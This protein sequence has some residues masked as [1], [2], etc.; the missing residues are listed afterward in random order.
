MQRVDLSALRL[1][2]MSE[3]LD[4]HSLS[5]DPVH[6]FGLWF[7][8]AENAGID[9]VNAMT[10]ATV[11]GAGRPSARIV[12]LKGFGPSGF[13]F[14]TNYQSRK[15]G[16]LSAQPNVSLLFF[17]QP[18]A[19]QVRIDGIAE[20]LTPKVNDAYFAT[21]PRESQIGAWASAQSTTVPNRAFIEAR[22]AEMTQ[23]FEGQNVP[24]PAYWGGFLVRP[25]AFEFWQG[26]PSRLHDRV[27][28]SPTGQA[29]WLRERLSP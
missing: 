14:F 5:P 19:R 1:E 26:R 27:R 25:L 16:E 11:D 7:K 13:E 4:E 20:Q 23:R 15:G 9:D 22:F 28:Y 18:L 29:N 6:Q 3:P 21:R 17:W 24:R 2:Y 8:E 10:L 12:L